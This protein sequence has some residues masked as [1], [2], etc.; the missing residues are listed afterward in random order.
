MKVVIMDDAAGVA[1]YGADIF[2]EQLQLKPA[3]VLG[4]ATEHRHP[5]AVRPVASLQLVEEGSHRQRHD[6]MEAR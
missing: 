6:A 2:R 5:S 3:S 4:L 1:R